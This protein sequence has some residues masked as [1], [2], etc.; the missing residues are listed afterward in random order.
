LPIPVF[1][2]IFAVLL[3]ASLGAMAGAM[4]GETWAGQTPDARWRIGKAAFVARLL[5]SL[6]K[7]IVASTMI[8][9]VLAALIYSPIVSSARF[10]TWS[11]KYIPVCRSLSRTGRAAGI[12]RLRLA[13]RIKPSVP[14]TG[15]ASDRAQRRAAKSSNTTVVPGCW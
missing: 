2:S 13:I 10:S 1:G 8:L 11:D 15:I 3:L 7:L 14:R 9:I 6:G 5:G 12:I 4:L